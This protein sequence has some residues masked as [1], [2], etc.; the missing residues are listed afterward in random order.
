M[1]S[2]PVIISSVVSILLACLTAAEAGVASSGGGI[3]HI[4]S[5]ADLARDGCSS[6]CGGVAIQYP[7][8]I[9][10]GCFRQGYE[11]T[12]N[13]T[14]SPPRLFLGRNSTTQVIDLYPIDN[15]ITTPTL[16]FNV[17]MKP[18][19]DTYNMSWEAPV[20]GLMVDG[21]NS[22]YVVGCG[23]VVYLFGHDTNVPI[24]SCM[25]IC[26]DNKDAMKEAYINQHHRIIGMGSCSIS[27]EQNVH[28]FGF[29][30]S[31]LTG[32]VSTLL[33]QSQGLSDSIKVFLADGYDFHLS[34]INSSQIDERN[35][36]GAS[37][38]MPI[39]DQPSCESAQK[40][41][42]SYACNGQSDCQDQQPGGY[43]CF[44]SGVYSSHSNPYI[45]DGCQGQEF[46][47]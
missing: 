32:G 9:G 5:A 12:C 26:L 46:T 31:R 36:Y 42:S 43:S 16:H 29:R 41:M 3:L 23:V 27:L 20:K 18:G 8:G 11:L 17:T 21:S 40:N 24:G 34:D 1:R 4:P 30:L 39:T 7:F 15:I 10:P 19:M 28:A 37:F 6:S 45:M 33:G 2:A 22:I 44:C 25:S 38:R 14:T 13:N 47:F 35:T